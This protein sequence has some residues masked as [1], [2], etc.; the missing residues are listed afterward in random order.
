MSLCGNNN[1]CPDLITGQKCGITYTGARYVPLFADPAQWDNTKA[2]EPLTIVL[3]EGNSYTSKTFV[4]IG[5]DISNETY[6]ALTGN[7]NAQVES[8]RKEVAEIKASNLTKAYRSDIIT[9][10]VAF[11]MNVG[12]I[13]ETSGYYSVNDGGGCKYIVVNV[14]DASCTDL[15]NGLF[16]KPVFDNMLNFVS[17]GGDNTKTKDNAPLLIDLLKEFDNIYFPKGQYSFMSVVDIGSGKVIKGCDSY[18]IDEINNKTKFFTNGFTFQGLHPVISNIIFYSNTKNSNYGLSRSDYINGAEITDCSFF[19]F[20]HGLYI[21]GNCDALR[22]D[23]CLFALNTNGATLLSNGAQIIY[24][25]W[26]NKCYFSNN[27]IGTTPTGEDSGWG[28]KIDSFN[29][30]TFTHCDTQ[31]NTGYG[32]FFKSS[33]TNV[34]ARNLTI[35]DC[36]FENNL[37]AHIHLPKI[38]YQYTSSN[39]V[40]TNGKNPPAESLIVKDSPINDGQKYLYFTPHYSES[41]TGDPLLNMG[42]NVHNINQ[43]PALFPY[44]YLNYP[45]SNVDNNLIPKKVKINNGDALVSGYLM[46]FYLSKGA[47]KFDFKYKSDIAISSSFLLKIKPA[48]TGELYTKSIS[49]NDIVEHEITDEALTITKSGIYMLQFENIKIGLNNSVL[50]YDFDIHL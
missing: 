4:P 48:T 8:Y 21:N 43:R 32:F 15:D 33:N 2:Y 29:D 23:G 35:N 31:A 36:Y 34:F 7:Y 19:Y 25:S 44:I 17:C 38:L 40:L 47:Y 37:S 41:T 26:F 13:L 16:L 24:N 49:V 42:V 30:I 1:P 10:A 45:V 22:F 18:V 6:W 12:D 27:G 5:I 46:T 28:I 3:N 39:C 20:E 50:V 14:K 11:P 9:N